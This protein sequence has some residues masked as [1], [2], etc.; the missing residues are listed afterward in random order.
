[1]SEKKRGASAPGKN[2]NLSGLTTLFGGNLVKV[3]IGVAALFAFVLII[4]LMFRGCGVKQGSPEKV[5]SSM[6]QAAGKGKT[7][8]MLK[9]YGAADNASQGLQK[10]V[11]ALAEYCKAHEPKDVKIVA[12]KTLADSKGCSY[13]FVTYNLVL[14]NEQEYPCIGTYLVKNKDDKYCIL[15]AS[16]ITAELSQFAADEYAKFMKTEDYHT[17]VKAY[18]AFIKKNPGYEARIEDKLR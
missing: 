3:V 15:Q 10:E 7:K 12:C 5:V 13:V 8:N 11:D 1:M 18:D 14:D 17:Y 4:S 9:C 2:P 16:D 6:I